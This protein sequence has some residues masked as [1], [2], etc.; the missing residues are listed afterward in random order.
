M[1]KVGCILGY[2]TNTWRNL[3]SE[4]RIYFWQQ[5]IRG[6]EFKYCQKNI[7]GWYGSRKMWILR[8]FWWITLYIP[9]FSMVHQHHIFSQFCSGFNK[10]ERKKSKEIAYGSSLPLLLYENLHPTKNKVPNTVAQS[11]E[12]DFAE[13]ERATKKCKHRFI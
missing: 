10:E 3:F 6:T 7:F 12:V 8:W 9:V 2:K 4:P 1:K 5:L 11:T 13:R